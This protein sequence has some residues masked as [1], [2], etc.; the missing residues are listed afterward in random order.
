[1]SGQIYQETS[2]QLEEK[3]KNLAEFSDEQIKGK[4]FDPLSY[5]LFLMENIMKPKIEFSWERLAKS[6]ERLWKMRQM[7]AMIR[8]FDHAKYEDGNYGS[9]YPL[10]SYLTKWEKPEKI[11]LQQCQMIE[12][13]G[14]NLNLSTFI[15]TYEQVI[16]DLY[17]FIFELAILDKDAYWLLQIWQEKYWI[18]NELLYD[19]DFFI[20]KLEIAEYGDFMDIPVHQLVWDWYDCIVAA[21]LNTEP[22]IKNG[23][24]LCANGLLEKI[25]KL[26]WQVDEY[27]WGWGVWRRGC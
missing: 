4:G 19:F 5:R 10:T 14:L 13:L 1:M 18:Y 22:Y 6:Q 23:H 24:M 12:I 26:G 8:D 27:P 15:K 2:K 3:L 20:L 17:N 21:N 11:T 25:Q 9:L 7:A 16:T